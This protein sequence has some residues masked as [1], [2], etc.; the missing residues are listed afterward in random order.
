MPR[1]NSKTDKVFLFPASTI[2]EV[3]GNAASGKT[4]AAKAIAR[5]TTCEYIP[6]NMYAKN[7]FV[8]ETAVHPARWTFT[9]HLYFSY[10]RSQQIPEIIKTMNL[11]PV[12]LDSGLD[13][14]LYV[15]TKN[16]FLQ[17]TISKDE[18]KFFQKLHTILMGKTPPIYATIF[19]HVSIEDSMK[20]IRDR[21]R[22]HEQ[23]YSWRYIEN[24]HDRLKE[25]KNDLVA[26]N[27]RK[28]VATY[29]QKE[30]RLEFHTKE[31]KKIKTLF[32][33]IK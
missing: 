21:G 2:I 6:V 26:L 15:Y 28:V 10:L 22:P 31:D 5:K 30:N 19:M 11:S 18:W 23:N 16:S 32:E 3:V 29:F 25:Y 27:S 33:L 12:V 4:T 9:N 20:R 1:V 7:P 24:L 8:D 13:V 17:G 14:G